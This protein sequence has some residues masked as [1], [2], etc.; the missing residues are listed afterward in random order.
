M[1][2]SPPRDAHGRLVVVGSVNVDLIVRASRLPGPGET[3]LGDDMD[4]HGGGKGGNA[5]IAA[6]RAGAQVAFIG[7]VGRDENGSMALAELQA[8][9]V[10]TSS[11]AVLEGPGTGVALI[12]VDQQGE[13]Q[14]VVAAGANRHV[15]ADHV[16]K[17][18]RQWLGGAS[19]VLVG[20]EIAGNAVLAAVEDAANAGVPCIINSAPVIPDLAEAVKY[21][22]LLTPNRTEALELL[23]LLEVEPVRE[24]GDSKSDW[25][26]IA[27]ALAQAT[28]SGVVITLGA[29]GAVVAQDARQSTWVETRRVEALDTTGAGDTFNG[30]LAAGLCRGESLVNAAKMAGIAASISVT[31]AGARTGMPRIDAIN[32]ALAQVP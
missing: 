14:I 11:V 20:T 19:C 26:A 31:A 8:E 17:S 16:H 24:G 29:E 4:R 18:L 2:M 3:V 6:A 1:S 13:N 28:G 23:E 7:A 21:G 5:A 30:V 9:G 22:A 12:V 27:R 15:T 32:H 10:D 25:M